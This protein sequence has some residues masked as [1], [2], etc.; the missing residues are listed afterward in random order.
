[1]ESEIIQL[2]SDAIK[3]GGQT[4]AWVVAVIYITQLLKAIITA[5][6]VVFTFKF[7][8]SSISRM[9]TAHRDAIVETGKR[10]G[11]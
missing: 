5:I 4:A 8:V 2:I 10:E 9:V 6:A 3:T 7:V 11:D 1:M